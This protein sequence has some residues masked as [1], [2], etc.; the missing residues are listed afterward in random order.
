[1][2]LIVMVFN[3]HH[4]KSSHGVIYIVT[5]LS[6]L[7]HKQAVTFS[8]DKNYIK[9]INTLVGTLLKHGTDADIFCRCV[10]FDQHDFDKI[11][12]IDRINII[13]D[14]IGLCN[15]KSILKD[16]TASVFYHYGIGRNNIRD[17]VNM[18]YSPRSVYTCHSRFKTIPELMKIGYDKILCLDVD[19][20]IN[21][22]INH[23][24]DEVEKYD[25]MTILTTVR[26]GQVIEY[27]GSSKFTN[28]TKNNMKCMFDEGMIV[29]NNTHESKKLWERVRDYI[30]SDDRWKQWN[31]DSYILNDLLNSDFSDLNIL[32]CDK[33]YKCSEC[34][35]GSYM[36]S[37]E[38]ITKSK[39]SFIDT[40]DQYN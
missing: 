17:I 16:D 25:M 21:K 18:L 40:V 10:D 34:Y 33:K 26:P 35:N 1:M 23:L 30:F 37:G 36:W 13:E 15:E 32:D 38:S 11:K 31:V 9:Y 12:N 29:I 6:H 14:N 5:Q 22:E 3:A 8:S 39:Q 4:G 24:F 2:Y 28:N 19:T 20:I 7:K 27:H